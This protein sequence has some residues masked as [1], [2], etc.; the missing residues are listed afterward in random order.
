MDTCQQV[1]SQ[2]RPELL[3]Q[4]INEPGKRA[5]DSFGDW[6]LPTDAQHTGI[7]WVLESSGNWT[8]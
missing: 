3:S 8:Q 4:R 2:D 6:L 7:P 1:L 5:L